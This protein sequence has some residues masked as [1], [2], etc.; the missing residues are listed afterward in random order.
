MASITDV[1]R[2]AGVSPS[3][4]SRLLN[5][6]PTL[7]IRDETRDRILAAVDELDYAP[8]HAA[9][10]LRR[11]HVGTLGL[12]VP[13]MH[14]PVY[15][16]ILA[17]A[18]PAAAEHG[19]VMVLTD[20]DGLA[21]DTTT[22][23]R[24]VRGGTIDGLMLQRDGS[25]ADRVVGRVASSRIPV[26]ILNERVRPPA[27]GVAVDD[28][29]AADLA[30]RHLVELGHVDVAHLRVRGRN[31]RSRDRQAGWEDRLK[32]AGIVPRA[33][34]LGYGGATPEAGYRGMSDLLALRR[35]PTAVFV[36]SVLAAVGA[37][38]AVRDSG[39]AVP[40]DV[41]VVGYHDTWFAEHA[42]PPLTVVRLPLADMGR[43]AVRVLVDLIA[44]K[45][46]QQLLITEPAPELVLRSSTAP[47][48]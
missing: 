34:L 9:R 8:N 13:D 16:A 44:G 26:A 39:R 14:N 47:P 43:Q 28:R 41:S 3:I 22:F 31:S 38:A 17:G 37:L 5:D 4:V 42:H 23:R 20:V 1:A 33:D 11:S 29:R 32:A 12:A 24:L 2:H 6:D 15:A 19:Y 36:G 25:V 21:S 18:R 48:H 35:P 45:P 30:T 10:A 46:P 40:D 7:R 27:S